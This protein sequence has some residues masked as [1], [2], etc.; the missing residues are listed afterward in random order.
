LSWQAPATSGSSPVGGY[1]IYRGAPGAT[2]TLLAVVG[3]VLAFTD[4]AVLNG[5]SYVYEISA[6]NAF[7]EGPR[8]SP[9]ATTRGTAPSAPL[10]LTATVGGPGI[11]ARWSAPASDGGTAVTGYRIFRGTTAANATPLTTVVPG[12]T[13]YVDK[14]VAKKTTYVYIVTATNVL[15]ESPPS[16]IVTATSH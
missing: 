3:N 5:G 2:R 16:N 15:G 12:V 6:V 13:S 4:T 10:G 7:G 1:R 14:S 9:V 11:T 8:S